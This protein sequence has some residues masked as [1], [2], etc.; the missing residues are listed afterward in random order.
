MTN[1]EYIKQN[2][3]AGRMQHLLCTILDCGRCPIKKRCFSREYH[4]FITPLIEEFT[5][6]HDLYEK[7]AGRYGDDE[8]EEEEDDEE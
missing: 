6:E 5:T 8:E 1:M 3:T 2:F 7:I 4:G